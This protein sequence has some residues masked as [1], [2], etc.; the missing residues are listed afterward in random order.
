MVAAG[1]FLLARLAV[2][3]Q[4]ASWL[5]EALVAIGLGSM[6]IGGFLAISRDDIKRLL[7]YSTIG[8]YGYGVV[9][10]GIGGAAGAVGA[11][12]Y[13]MAHALA[14]S[15]LF[16][17]AGAVTEATGARRLSELGGLWR[18][19]PLLAIASGIAAATLA[20]LPLTIGFF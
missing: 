2:L 14:K 20:A 17:T 10:L 7:A 3:V 6:A 19:V 8:Q 1:V 11:G 13:V 5:P 12:F 9:M 18:G 4:R 15:A 16:L